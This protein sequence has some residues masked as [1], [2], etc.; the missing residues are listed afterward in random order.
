MPKPGLIVGINVTLANLRSTGKHL[1][2]LLVEE[3]FFLDAEVWGNQVQVQIVQW[4]TGSTL[5]G[6]CHAVRT[7]KNSQQCAT[8]RHMLSPPTEDW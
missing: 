6:P 3:C 2:R 1:A 7:S 5:F 8:L 4:P